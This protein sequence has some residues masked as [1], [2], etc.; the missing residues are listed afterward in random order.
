[1]FIAD[2]GGCGEGT[3]F[4]TGFVDFKNANI[5]FN[6]SSVMLRYICHGIGGSSDRPLSI[7]FNFPCLIAVMKLLSS[8]FPIPVLSEVRLPVYEMPHGPTQQ[9]SVWVTI[10]PFFSTAFLSTS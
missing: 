9:V 4:S 6:S 10:F 8:Q 3:I 7:P 5:A 2:A 1:Y